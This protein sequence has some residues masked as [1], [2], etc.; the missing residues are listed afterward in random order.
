MAGLWLGRPAAE[1]RSQLC[2]HYR[3]QTFPFLCDWP[4]SVFEMG[5]G[6]GTASPAKETRGVGTNWELLVPG[7]PVPPG[8]AVSLR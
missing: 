1:A 3:P 4:G 6:L 8:K 2:L 7:G 5:V